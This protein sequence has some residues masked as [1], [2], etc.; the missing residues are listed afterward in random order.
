MSDGKKNTLERWVE[1]I[2]KKIDPSAHRTAGSGCIMGG[3][4]GDVA[5]KYFFIECKIRHTKENI[6]MQWKKEWISLLDKIP[7][8]SNKIPML[9]T[10]NKYGEKFVIL[11]AHEFFSIIEKSYVPKS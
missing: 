6:F 4:A 10:E 8:K 7:M 2:L 11:E 1:T 5:N 3:S 9:V